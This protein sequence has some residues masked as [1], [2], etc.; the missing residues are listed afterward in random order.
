MNHSVNKFL[1]SLLMFKIR[2]T[3]IK[4]GFMALHGKKNHPR[5]SMNTDSLIV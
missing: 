1:N 2:K 5:L 4:R 3:C